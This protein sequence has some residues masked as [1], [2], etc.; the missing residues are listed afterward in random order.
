M[1]DPIFTLVGFVQHFNFNGLQSYKCLSW[2]AFPQKFAAPLAA[3]KYVGSENVLE[4]QKRHGSPLSLSRVWWG[5]NLSRVWWG[6]NFARTLPGGGG[7]KFHV[8]CP[9]CTLSN[10]RDYERDF[11]IKTFE[12]GNSVDI[13]GWGRFVHVVVHLDS[14]LSLH[15]QMAPPCR[16]R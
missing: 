6:S 7:K 5:S 3:K 4:V 1:A 2:D 10:G 14:T 9:S 13:I 8:F 15:R 11:A 16:K 12:Y